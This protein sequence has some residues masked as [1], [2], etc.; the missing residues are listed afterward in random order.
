MKI[1]IFDTTLRDGEQAPGFT[2]H[3]KEK[4]DVALRL[5]AM[6]VD[7]IEAGF[8]ACSK[9]DFLSV[10][11]IAENVKNSSVMALAR[12]T[13][14]DIDSA[15]LAL[16]SAANP[17]LHVFI[18]TSPIHLK[19]KLKMTE[20]EV[21]ESIAYHAKYAKNKAALVKYAFE[22]ATR[23]PR[24]FLLKAVQTAVTAGADCINIAD[25]VGYSTPREMAELVKYL[26]SNVDVR[27]G[28]HCHNDLGLATAN[29]LS[30]IEAG[31]EDFDCAVIG[32]GERAGN[33]SLEE[34]V[35]AL[36][37]R[38]PEYELNIDTKQIYGAAKL[39]SSIVGVKLPPFKTIVGSNAFAHEAGIHQHG[40]LENRATYELMNPD[41]IGIP[42][43]KLLLGKHSGKH[44]FLELIGEMGYTLTPEEASFYFEKFK[45]F[46]ERKKI[47]TRRDIDALLINISRH[48]IKRTYS[49]TDYEIT[50]Y[51][52]QATAEITL[53]SGNRQH[54]E[55][56]SGD[57]PV[58][59][60]F[61]AINSLTG[62][63]F[64][65]NDYSIHSVTEGKDALGEATVKLEL[66]GKI[67][68]GKGLST[69]VLEA[70]IIAY[71][72]AV[73][74]LISDGDL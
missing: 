22:D 61:K 45:D 15:V 65:L 5:E 39:V 23:T 7:A 63:N 19:Y 31:A 33:A 2:M 25:T 72:N 37:T 47:V 57:G 20:D 52:N 51:K 13:A 34:V 12:S 43:N 69:D 24:E 70:S 29:T 42:Q 49:L 8:P 1:K 68:T 6:N 36:K 55:K 4:L 62:Q 11:E 73:N 48:A 58:D 74:K 60:A 28:V 46:A 35:M 64:I 56:M 41:D 44:A 40:V 10:K 14:Q 30:A 16:Q 67:M 9:A 27:L 32:L 66:D 54:V 18:A 71:L 53:S 59:A 50:S 3:P 21:L 38:Y 26:K 17:I